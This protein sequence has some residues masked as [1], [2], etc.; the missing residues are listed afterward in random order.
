MAFTRQMA[1]RD[2]GERDEYWPFEANLA[3]IQA[4]R[5]LPLGSLS[6]TIMETL[7]PGRTSRL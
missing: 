1:R 3:L 4:V 5:R 7:C 6:Q 2:G